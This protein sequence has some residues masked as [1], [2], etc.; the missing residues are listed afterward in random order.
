MIEVYYTVN[1][2]ICVCMTYTTPYVFTTHLW[3]HGISVSAK[4]IP[5]AGEWT[6]ARELLV[7]KL[8]YYCNKVLTSTLLTT[9]LHGFMSPALPTPSIQQWITN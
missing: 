1:L 3:I 5:P 9:I 2:Y 8:C 4:E 7:N 6:A